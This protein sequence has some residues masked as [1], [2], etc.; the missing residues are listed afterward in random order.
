MWMLPQARN[1]AVE[2]GLHG[3]FTLLKLL[4]QNWLQFLFVV[5]ANAIKQQKSKYFPQIQRTE[6]SYN[7][8]ASQWP[9]INVKARFCA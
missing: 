4:K 8:Y 2:H 6:A 7:I 3:S 1:A 9:V 5:Q